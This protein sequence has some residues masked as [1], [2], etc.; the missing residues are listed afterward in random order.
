MNVQYQYAPLKSDLLDQLM[1]R[2]IETF[3]TKLI[4]YELIE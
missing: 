1:T 2:D 3:F 4:N